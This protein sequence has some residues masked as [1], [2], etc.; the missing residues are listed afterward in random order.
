MGCYRERWAA[1][2]GAGLSFTAPCCV[3]GT[4]VLFWVSWILTGS[5]GSRG[6]KQEQEKW[7]EGGMTVDRDS[8][9]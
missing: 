5:T 9:D 2:L 6:G 8:Q 1:S 4:L 7:K 3:V